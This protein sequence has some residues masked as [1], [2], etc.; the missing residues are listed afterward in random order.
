MTPLEVSNSKSV[1]VAEKNMK[2]MCGNEINSLHKQSVSGVKKSCNHEHKLIRYLL[3]LLKNIIG[4]EVSMSSVRIL[5]N[6]FVDI[7]VKPLQTVIGN[8]ENSNLKFK[9]NLY[10]IKGEMLRVIKG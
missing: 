10:V 7:K 6:A 1:E 9:E 3:N 4:P 2:L 8:I 5:L